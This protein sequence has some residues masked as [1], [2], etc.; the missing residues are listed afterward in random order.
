MPKGYLRKGQSLSRPSV[1]HYS[2]EGVQGVCGQGWETPKK[3]LFFSK[4]ILDNSVGAI[5][6]RRV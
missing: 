2:H 3:P 1:T 6:I 5:I 4:K